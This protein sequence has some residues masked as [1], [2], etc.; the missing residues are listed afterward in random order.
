MAQIKRDDVSICLSECLL[1][2]A[3]IIRAHS[4]QVVRVENLCRLFSSLSPQVYHLMD[5][6]ALANHNRES[7]QLANFIEVWSHHSNRLR[8]H[9]GESA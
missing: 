3:L 8:G 5:I 2:Q 7:R 6:G 1:E 9:A 4:N